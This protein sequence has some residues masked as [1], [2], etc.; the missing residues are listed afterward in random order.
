MGGE[1]RGRRGVVDGL[2]RYA[3]TPGMKSPASPRSGPLSYNA[4]L[5]L[6]A[7]VRGFGYGFD[8]MR[9]TGLPSGTVYPLLRRLEAG[10][11]VR[12]EWEQKAEAHGEGRPARRNYQ[13]TAIGETALAEALPRIRAQRR[14]LDEVWGDG[15]SGA[16][17]SG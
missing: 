7:I 11:M 1:R 5:V 15:E 17:A 13:P 8:I 12:S 6:Q 2:C 14:L 3:Y 16:P 4:T 9:A 10:G